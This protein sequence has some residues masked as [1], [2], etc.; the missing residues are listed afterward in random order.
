MKRRLALPSFVIALLWALQLVISPAAQAASDLADGAYRIDYVITKAEND[1]VSM[2][3]DYF[4]KPALLNVKSGEI[5]AQI[6]LNHSKWI[7]VFK[8]PAGSD[9][10]D[11]KVIR[12]DKEEDTR[13]VQFKIDD[14]SKP[15]ISKIHVT[16]PDIDYDHDYTIRFI[17]DPKT[18]KST[19]AAP[20]KSEP[21]A[22]AKPSEAT[23]NSAPAS[24]SPG[25]KTAENSKSGADKAAAGQSAPV[26]AAKS[27]G[28]ANA[29]QGSAVVNPQTGDEAPIGMLAGMLVV[30][31]LFVA[32]QIHGRKRRQQP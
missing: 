13:V 25:S 1:S 16:V 7:T 23:K 26:S 15:L 10:A 24:N 2:A 19:E 21:P 9:F 31:G 5:T 4:E 27:S 32:Y 3:N 22:A 29:G 8:T 20:A 14:L 30:S 28:S 17:F 12:S 11:A 6:Q 18:I